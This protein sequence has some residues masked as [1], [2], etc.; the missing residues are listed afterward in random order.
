MTTLGGEF[1]EIV[2][3]GTGPAGTAAISQ[4]L[5]K[6][7]APVVL[8]S[9]STMPDFAL[10]QR[11]EMRNRL[12]Q[13]ST[14]EVAPNIDKYV[15]GRPPPIKKKFGSDFVFAKNSSVHIE[16]NDV[17]LGVSFARGGLSNVW[18]ASCM[19]FSPSDIKTW[20]IE[21]KDLYANLED[22]QS[23]I[24][25]SSDQRFND[26]SPYVPKSTQNRS[27]NSV[28][29][30][31]LSQKQTVRN[32]EMIALASC[33]AVNTERAVP[34]LC[35]KCRACLRGCPLDAIFSADA[36]IEDFV[37]KGLDYRPN[38]T[39]I[40]LTE[41][42]GGVEILFVDSRNQKVKIHSRKV[43]LACGPV[44]STAL[45][46]GALGEERSA[47][48]QECA[49]V[50]IPLISLKKVV[51][52][53]HGTTLADL[54]VEIQDTKSNTS[55]AHFQCY[56]PSPELTLATSESVK[57]F[58]LPKF[59]TG[60]LSTRA[61]VAHGF[62][63]PTISPGIS[64]RVEHEDGQ[65]VITANSSGFL[66]VDLSRKLLKAFRRFLFFGRILTITPLAHQEASGRSYH[67]SSS[68]PMSDEARQWNTSDLLGRPRGLKFI[69]VVD[70]TVLPVVPPQSPT[71]TVMCN[72]ARISSSLAD[73]IS[74]RTQTPLKD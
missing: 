10:K 36:L 33:L 21:H 49:S 44:M 40:G 23:I 69:H 70:A 39:V 66:E 1:L 5:K 41:V 34:E 30:P 17:D 62:F 58:H 4:L 74:R 67:L 38:S 35:K 42:D 51:T 9:G 60:L 13:N 47:L 50:T 53:G 25:I 65:L 61:L 12:L 8:D 45:V 43:V 18:G 24:E 54:F 27:M 7:V 28:Y 63:S 55:K 22:I 46:L 57:R 29:V 26:L 32:Y 11:L 68:F 14:S 71:L 59:V 31:L 19:L 72:A 52:D 48:L 37:A 2:V 73:D 56:G 16:Q 20:P 6:G 3:I 15:V 64:I